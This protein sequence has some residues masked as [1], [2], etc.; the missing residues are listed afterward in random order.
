MKA[1]EILFTPIVSFSVLPQLRSSGGDDALINWS[2]AGRNK[3]ERRHRRCYTFGIVALFTIMNAF[4]LPKVGPNYKAPTNAV[5]QHYKAEELGSWKEASPAD[6]LSKGAWWE[7]FNDA[8]LNELE[9]RAAA[10]NQDLKAAFA[11]VEQARLTARLSRTELLPNLAFDPSLRRERYSPNQQPSFGALTATTVRVPFDLSYEIDLW[12]RVRRGMEATR[13]GAQSSVA[14]FQ[15]VLL[16]LQGDVAQTYFS[17]RSLDAEIAT[18]TGTIELRKEQLRLV[19][20]RFEGGVGNELDVA[21]AETELATTESEASALARRRMEYEN[22]LAVLVGEFA[23]NFK[24]A[25]QPTNTPAWTMPAPEIPAGLP[26]ELLERRPDV[27][28]AERDLAAANA[29]I[30]VAK[31]AYFPVVSLTGSGGFVS[32]EFSNVFDWSSRIWSIGPS[33]SLPIFAQARNRANVQRTRAA[34]TEAAAHY[35][36]QVLVAF[37]EVENNLAAIRF[38]AEQAAAQERAVASSQRA[39]DLARQRYESGISTYLEVVDANRATLG[40]Q[41]VRAQLNGQR[42]IASVQLIKS[43]GGGWKVADRL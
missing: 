28:Q 40:A 20:S 13:A 4:A 33:I 2:R 38:I 12:G 6:G 18:V 36:A 21:R 14:A 8:T 25:A 10:N 23:S 41:R 24:F 3:S 42:L 17:L 37:S 1:I 43:L 30:G 9:A 34:F 31:A 15:N 32:A 39:A 26:A 35:R 11:R 5:P 7:V 27:A 22:A 16:T 29:R 19:R